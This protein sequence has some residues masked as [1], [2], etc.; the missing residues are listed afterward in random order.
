MGGIDRSRGGKAVVNP[1][2]FVDSS[3]I[4]RQGGGGFVAEIAGDEAHHALRVLRIAPGDEVVVLDDS[5]L[6][7]HGRVRGVASR[8]KP[9][10]FWVQ[11]ETIEPA[12]GEPPFRVCLVQALPKGDKMDLV[13]QKGT[14][15]GS[16]ISR[17]RSRS[18]SWSSMTRARPRLAGRAGKRIAQEAAKQGGRGRRP[19]VAA[20]RPV[21]Q[22]LV[23]LKDEL[24]LVLWEQ[25]ETPI[26][27]VLRE[28]NRQGIGGVALVVG[29]EGGFSAREVEAMEA[30]GARAVLFG[31]S[32]LAHG[33]GRTCTRQRLSFTSGKEDELCPPRRESASSPT[34]TSPTGRERFLPS[35]TSSFKGS[36]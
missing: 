19:Q 26:K 9:P 29:P 18:E 4:E 3:A 23:D 22:C 12:A 27:K 11:G 6:E 1:R 32:H 24:I 35:S 2:F 20:I 17:P 30:L 10:R 7:Y 13:V 16:P 34:R 21:L 31:A 5:G 28:E 15:V 8:D 36:P 14:E 25:A 33:D